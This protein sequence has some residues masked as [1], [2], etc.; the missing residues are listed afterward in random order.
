[1]TG[2]GDVDS[3]RALSVRKWEI[4]GAVVSLLGTI[5]FTLLIALGGFVYIPL[6]FTPVPITMQVLFVL[7][8]GLM[9]GRRFGT[10]SV[11]L[12]ITAGVAG[13]PIFAGAVGGLARIVG[14]TGGYLLG[15]LLSP[16]I[17]TLLSAKLTRG[18]FALVVSLCAGLLVIYACGT[19]HLAVVLRVP[20]DK[21]LQIGIYPFIPGDILKIM[22]ALSVV[23]LTRRSSW[24]VLKSFRK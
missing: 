13:F 16:Y 24:N 9:L 4:P 10:L 20:F 1:M 6:P 18:F 7:L 2:G 19:I 3:V 21:A 5:T 14:P 23:H 17:V 11:L 12:Y 22:L 8:A 15:F